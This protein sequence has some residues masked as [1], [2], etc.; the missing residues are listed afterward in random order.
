MTSVSFGGDNGHG[1]DLYVTVASALL[2]PLSG[3]VSQTNK[4]GTS[5]YRISGLG[6]G[7]AFK[8][9]SII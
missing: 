9:L 3:K 8:R 5:L 6:K 2:D 1:E 7:T 4:P